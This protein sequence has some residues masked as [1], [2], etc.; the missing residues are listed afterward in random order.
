MREL[1]DVMTRDIGIEAIFC[2][3]PATVTCYANGMDL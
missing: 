1:L 3:W 2:D